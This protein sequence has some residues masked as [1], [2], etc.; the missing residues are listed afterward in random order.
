MQNDTNS[1]PGN[2]TKRRIG[3]VTMVLLKSFPLL[4]RGG[5]YLIHWKRKQWLDRLL[6]LIVEHK[7]KVANLIFFL[8]LAAAYA[9]WENTPITHRDRLLWMKWWPWLIN[10]LLEWVGAA[11]SYYCR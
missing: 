2:V 8:A 11:T 7:F 4:I 10:R 9:V 6:E 3:T 1:D 5:I